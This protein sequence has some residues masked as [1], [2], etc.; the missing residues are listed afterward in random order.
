VLSFDDRRRLVSLESG[1]AGLDTMPGVE[2]FSGLLV[3]AS[4][5]FTPGTTPGAILI[6]RVGWETLAPAPGASARRIL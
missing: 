5:T 3:P 1:V 2:F 4:G 6:D